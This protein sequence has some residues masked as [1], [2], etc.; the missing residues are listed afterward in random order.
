MNGFPTL[1]L[2]KDGKKAEEYSGK[3]E[4]EQLKA[5]VDKHLKKDKVEL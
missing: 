4:L 1:N 5:F 2:Y 3:R